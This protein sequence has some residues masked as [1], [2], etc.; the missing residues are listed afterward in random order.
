M[1]RICFQAGFALL[2]FVSACQTDLKKSPVISKTINANWTFNYLPNDAIRIDFVDTAF[3]DSNWQAIALPH[4]WSTYET[5]GDLHPFIANPS[6]RDDP[7]WYQGWGY[8]RKH[9][10]FDPS[11]KGKKVFVEFDAVQKYSKVYVNGKLVGDHKGGFTSF[12]FDISDFVRWDGDNLMVV[13]ASNRKNDELRI[14]PMS[15]GNWDI[16]GG[17]YRDVRL[18]IKDKL[19]IPFQGSYQH[20]GGVYITTPL[21]N[22]QNAVAVIK[23][24]VKNDNE[25]AVN[26][27]LTTTI[28]DPD[29]ALLQQLKQ[30]ATIL[31]GTLYCFEQHTDTLKNPRLWSPDSPVLVQGGHQPQP[32]WR[33]N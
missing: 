18:V 12:Y 8:Y 23:T 1:Y 20:E 21:V 4:T 15:G 3:D 7:Y 27:Q 6:E 22:E 29:G 24:Y 28:T 31:P 2:V 26:C 17:I 5:T 14:A 10:S 30:K 13:A 25:Q 11:L 9:F 32:G 16:Y 33:R 19:Y